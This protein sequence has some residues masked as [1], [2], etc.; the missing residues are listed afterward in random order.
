MLQIP[1]PFVGH[2]FG[3][4]GE[5]FPVRFPELSREFPKP[6]RRFVLGPYEG[7]DLGQKILFLHS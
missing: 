1:F 4:F 5:L 7:I 3:S 6:V 2:F